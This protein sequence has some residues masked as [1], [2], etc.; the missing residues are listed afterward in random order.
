[1]PDY[2]LSDTFYVRFYTKKDR[3]N[4]LAM[5]RD[6]SEENGFAFNEEAFSNYIDLMES[7]GAI[8]IAADKQNQVVGAIALIE[9]K[10]PFTGKRRLHQADLAV[11]KEHRNKGIA[12]MLQAKA[13]EYGKLVGIEEYPWED[14][15]SD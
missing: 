8:L 15:S 4:C 2:E 11:V 12:K 9:V 5:A 10:N 1:M 13:E 6:Y 7:K 3:E 14:V